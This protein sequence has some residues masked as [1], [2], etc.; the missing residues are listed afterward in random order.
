MVIG[1][2]FSCERRA[3]SSSDTSTAQTSK[4]SARAS[5]AVSR[6]VALA[7][8]I[9][10]VPA[11]ATSSAAVGPKSSTNA[12]SRSG[13]SVRTS[14]AG[15]FFTSAEH[16]FD[17]IEQVALVLRLIAGVGPGLELL[18]GQHPRELLDDL[19]LFA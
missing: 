13:A 14:I 5:R 18:F 2:R 10:T 15:Y 9:R 17:A 1:F 3:Q 6:S 4:R 19:L 7:K 12:S 11:P 16:V 8:K